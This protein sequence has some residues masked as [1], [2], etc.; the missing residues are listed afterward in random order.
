MSTTAEHTYAGRPLMTMED[1]Y[2]V[3]APE[4]GIVI[5]AMLQNWTGD[6]SAPDPD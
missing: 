6:G 1:G 5:P 2:G 3:A 4:L